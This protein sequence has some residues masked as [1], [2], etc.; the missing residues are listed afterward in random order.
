MVICVTKVSAMVIEALY[1][2]HV[3]SVHST[4]IFHWIMPFLLLWNRVTKIISYTICNNNNNNNN[5]LF[6]LV[7]VSE[8]KCSFKY[9]LENLRM[10]FGEITVHMQCI[11][12]CQGSGKL[13]AD[14]MTSFDV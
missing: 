3:E 1:C 7:I 6:N 11:K 14:M 9:E 2:L 12:T 4:S 5:N 10:K 8:H 13:Y